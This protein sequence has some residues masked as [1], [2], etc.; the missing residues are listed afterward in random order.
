MF[1]TKSLSFVCLKQRIS[2]YN[3]QVLTK[4]AVSSTYHTFLTLFKWMWK[5]I[6]AWIFYKKVITFIIVSLETGTN[7]P[8]V[9]VKTLLA[10]AMMNIMQRWNSTGVPTQSQLHTA[11][12]TLSPWNI[13]MQIQG[14]HNAIAIYASAWGPTA[15]GTK[16][17]SC[18]TDFM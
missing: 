3:M 15:R 8:A 14:Q 12:L 6:F 1:H 18:I 2:H 13:T 16:L 4:R 10:I 9:S 7:F 5:N 11:P 17:A